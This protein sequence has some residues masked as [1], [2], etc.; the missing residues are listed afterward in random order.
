MVASLPRLAVLDN[1]PITK[2]EKETSKT[3]VSEFYEYLPYKHNHK[4][5]VVNILQKRETGTSGVHYGNSSKLKQ[6]YCY[7]KSQCFFSRSLSAARFG[8]SMWPSLLPVSSFSHIYKEENK[9]LRPRQFEYHPS[10][11]SLMAFGTLDG[12][13]VVVNHETGNLVG[14]NSS[15]GMINSVLG[16]C[17][18]KKHPSKVRIHFKC[19]KL[20]SS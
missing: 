2:K 18:L 8:S 17:W 4:K 13:I 3:V 1:L 10:N 20:V 5:N 7:G 11:S 14:Y 16:L 6:T 15:I 9:R 19:V 12:E